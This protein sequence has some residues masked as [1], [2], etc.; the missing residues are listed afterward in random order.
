M[1]SQ[2]AVVVPISLTRDGE[3][4]GEFYTQ[5]YSSRRTGS[6][7]MNTFSYDESNNSLQYISCSR[8]SYD[9]EHDGFSFHIEVRRSKNGS[10]IR[11]YSAT[12]DN[13]A[14]AD[15]ERSLFLQHNEDVLYIAD[16][17]YVFTRGENIQVDIETESVSNDTIVETYSFTDDMKSTHSFYVGMPVYGKMMFTDQFDSFEEAIEFYHNGF[18]QHGVDCR[19]IQQNADGSTVVRFGDMTLWAFNDETLENYFFSRDLTTLIHEDHYD[20]DVYTG[21]AEDGDYIPSDEEFTRADQEAA[22]ALV[23]MQN[24]TVDEAASGSESENEGDT[25][26]FDLSEMRLKPYGKGYLLV[27]DKAD[28]VLAGTKYFLGGWWLPNRNAW[29]FKEHLVQDLVDLGAKKMR[30]VEKDRTGLNSRKVHWKKLER[31]YALVPKEDY[32]HYGKE[33]FRGG[34]WWK[35]GNAWFFTDGARDRYI[36]QY[37]KTSTSKT[38]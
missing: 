4:D 35:N 16:E 30:K 11:L 12:Y 23:E 10:T 29:F 18:T 32:K 19:I 13:H 31:G 34:T 14:E 25:F 21:S 20:V 37:G 9:K 17:P 24:E 2:Y 26:M 1:T 27:P 5:Y 38:K 22:E 3:S 33:T 8:V 7:Y 36:A 6:K 28:D 15:E